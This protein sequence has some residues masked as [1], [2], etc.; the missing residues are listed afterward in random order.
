MLA[1]TGATGRIGHS[2]IEALRV[3][4]RPVRAVVRDPERAKS[5]L[6]PG[7]ELARG[8]LEDP[9]S[10]AA[11]FAGADTLYLLAMSGQNLEA[12]E[13][14]ALE[15]AVK[16]GIRRV[17]YHSA[18]GAD[19]ASAIALARWHAATEE[20]LRRS[21]LAWTILR[22][23]SFMQNLLFSVESIRAHGI[24]TGA[25]GEGR[26]ASVDAR[27][28]ASSAAAVLTSGG[29][30]GKLYRLTGPEALTQSEVAAELSRTL[31]RPVR[32]QNLTTTE[33]LA[34]LRKS[35]TPE[36]LAQ[37]LVAIEAFLA[38]GGE[39][40]VSPDV[41]RLTGRPPCRFAQFIRDHLDAFRG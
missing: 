23:G 10:L 18:M 24:F 1:V 12:H 27:D 3:Q 16:A 28:L 8:D 17:V 35:G 39:A 33:L 34:E 21:S 20:R 5:M 13:R 25:S 4:D 31:G 9:A 11:A 40:Q 37:D 6:G 36:W 19:P 7:V 14:N 32:Y 22:A 29:H 2:L 15:A 30:E 41:E 26:I 38:R